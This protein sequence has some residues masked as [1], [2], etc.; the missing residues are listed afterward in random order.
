M[1]VHTLLADPVNR[2]TGMMMPDAKSGILYG[3]K[4]SG[5]SGKAVENPIMPYENDPKLDDQEPEY[6]I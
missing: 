4:N 6:L 5:I 2:R 1:R 3:P